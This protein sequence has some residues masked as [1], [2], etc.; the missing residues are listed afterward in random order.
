M[1]A[2][3]IGRPVNE[4]ADLLQRIVNLLRNAQ[5]QHMIAGSFASTYYGAVRMTQDIDIIIDPTSST[6][7]QLIR[8]LPEDSYYVDETAARDALL[9]RSM[10]NVI[11]LQTGWK[12]DF[13]EFERR[14]PAKL[15]DVETFVASPGD[16]ILAK[17]EWAAM[18]GSERQ[19]ADVMGMVRAKQGE[20]DAQYLQTWAQ[21]LNVTDLW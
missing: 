14:K 8:Q 12:I 4:S 21:E 2:R 9:R 10:F 15:F 20:L 6:L 18:S 3:S 19:L 1:A 13:I 5:I 11:D 7:L 16:V 17:L